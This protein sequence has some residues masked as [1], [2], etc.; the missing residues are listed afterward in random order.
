MLGFGKSFGKSCL[1][2]ALLRD[3][4]TALLRDNGTAIETATRSSK[5]P[6]ITS[7][8]FLCKRHPVITGL[9]SGSCLLLNFDEDGS[10]AVSLVTEESVGNMMISSAVECVCACDMARSALDSLKRLAP[11]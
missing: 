11:R 5:I 8:T 9:S 4:G 6:M 1:E 2:A 10:A 7:S 3:N